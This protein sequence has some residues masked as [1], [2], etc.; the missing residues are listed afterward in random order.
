M[1]SDIFASK[2]CQEEREK[3][4]AERKKEKARKQ[5]TVYLKVRQFSGWPD[6]AG[7]ER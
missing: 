4:Q 1:L 7:E 5:E 6:K 3:K 2:A